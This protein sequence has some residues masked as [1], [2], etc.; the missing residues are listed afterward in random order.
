MPEGPFYNPVRL[1]HKPGLTMRSAARMA[2][3]FRWGLVAL[4]FGLAAQAEERAPSPEPGV[5]LIVGGELTG[6]IA[7]EDRG[8]FNDV[9]YQ[10][11]LLRLF[12]ASLLAE[13]RAGSRVALL[14]EL[15]SENLDAPQAYALYLRVRP[16]P[17]H[18]FDVQ[19]GRIPPVFGAFARRRYGQDNPLVGSPLGY[20]YLT[21]VRPDAVPANADELLGQRGEGWLTRYSVGSAAYDA[22]LPVVES[23]R[24]DT[25]IEMRI[26]GE[27]LEW[28][29]AV[30]QGSL[31]NPRLSDDND[32][33]QISTRLAWY[34]TPGLQLGGSF[35]LGEY[36]AEDVQR[37]LAQPG[38]FRQQAFGLD[39]EYSWARFLVRS[40]AIVSHWQMPAIDA[41]RIDTPL[42]VVAVFLEARYRAAPGLNVAAR[43]DRLAFGR[44]TG[45]TGS[46]TWDA[47]VTRVEA[48]VGY[49]VR[50][51][52]RLKAGYQ[53]NWRD[54]GFVHSQGLLAGQIGVWF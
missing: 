10:R 51:H 41:P 21:T 3:R 53:Y 15:R 1:L 30:T 4:G 2:R 12:R 36:L 17:R 7:P 26:G 33:K 5:R 40:E 54:G 50:R 31:G 42:D 13:L 37:L 34:P 9:D 47:P 29:V 22:G 35:A 43:V 11:N 49:A 27:P 46:Q 24:W 18:A 52:V 28:S 6:T 19:L 32:G 44:I 38:H 39:V 14:G 45:S 23:M 48:A 16:L 25:G 8:F 20:Q